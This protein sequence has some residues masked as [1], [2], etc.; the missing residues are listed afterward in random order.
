MDVPLVEQRPAT[1]RPSGSRSGRSGMR[2]SARKES[3]PRSRSVSA[4]YGVKL[5]SAAMRRIVPGQGLLDP[6]DGYAHG[7]ADPQS[8]AQGF[9]N[10]YPCVRLFAGQ[11]DRD[12]IARPR[13]LAD[14]ERQGV[15][16]SVHRRR[17]MQA[18]AVELERIE[19]R[20]SL[21]E[22]AAGLFDLFRPRAG[23]ELGEPRR[24]DF[25]SGAGGFEQVA[26]L[27]DALLRCQIAFAQSGQPVQF[28]LSEIAF[29]LGFEQAGA[30]GFDGLD[31]WTVDLFFEQRLDAGDIG[32][33]LA[34][35]D[36]EPR[37][38]LPQDQRADGKRIAFKRSDFDDG[39][40]RFRRL[41]RPGRI[42]VARRPATAAPRNRTARARVQG[43]SPA[44]IF[45]P[46]I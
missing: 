34:N 44:Q 6:V 10:V 32:L 2:T 28:A 30:S 26:R 27:V 9:G 37:R 1:G 15:D 17:H 35:A 25:D 7:A 36:V 40:V 5:A 11:Q 23:F 31:S 43:R 46:H 41:L 29:D 14:F 39:L 21:A 45:I 33:G 16:H 22:Q 42:R 19:L 20:S 12:H 4:K 24:D 38:V 3:R 18:F 13:P 8:R